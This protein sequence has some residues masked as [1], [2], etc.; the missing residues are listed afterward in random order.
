MGANASRSETT[1]SAIKTS[2]IRAELFNVGPGNDGQNQ[3]SYCRCFS[4]EPKLNLFS[5]LSVD[6]FDVNLMP[7]SFIWY[8]WILKTVEYKMKHV[9][10]NKVCLKFADNL[11]HARHH[12]QMKS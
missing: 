4:W 7:I 11:K 5:D 3:P 8:E 10:L 2:Q 9:F 6:D 1:R 12:N